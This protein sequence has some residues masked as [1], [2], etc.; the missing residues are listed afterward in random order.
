MKIQITYSDKSKLYTASLTDL[1]LAQTNR[2][3]DEG[4]PM[5]ATSVTKSDAVLQL[6]SL[7]PDFFHEAIFG[8]RQA[9]L[10]EDLPL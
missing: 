6:V 5:E 2:L 10:V 8:S 7:L 3:L 1:N 4:L 9:N